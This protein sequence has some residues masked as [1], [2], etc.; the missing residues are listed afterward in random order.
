MFTHSRSKHVVIVD[1]N[2][3]IGKWK[4]IQTDVTDLKDNVGDGKVIAFSLK[5][6]STAHIYF[7]NTDGLEKKEGRWYF[8]LSKHIGT[9]N[10]GSTINTDLLV[11]FMI[12]EN[13][14]YQLALK[15]DKKDEECILSS[16]EEKFEKL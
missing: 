2:E 13:N 11:S 1:R 10:H 16:G 7:K 5:A 14:S 9:K 15:I 8:S 12:S 6:D 3:L 4:V